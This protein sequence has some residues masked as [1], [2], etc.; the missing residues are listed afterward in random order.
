MNIAVMCYVFPPEV[1]PAGVM[2]R[3]LAEDLAADGHRVTLLVSW[4]NHPGGKLKEGWKARF[5]G[6]EHLSPR[7]R[8]VRCL[9]TIPNRKRMISRLMFYF[10]FGLTAMLNGLASGPFDVVLNH[11]TPIFGT[12]LGWLLARLKGA[13]LVYDIYD[14][15]PEAAAHAGLIEESALSYRVL[16][17]MDAELCRRADAI[18]TLSESLKRGIVERGV[19]GGKI[20]L[21]PLWLDPEKFPATRRDNPWRRAQG[22]PKDKFVALFAGTIGY[23]SGALVLADVAERLAGRQDILLL[24][25]GEGAVKD[26]LEAA[27]AERGLGN[28]M[29]LPYQPAEALANM[30]AAADVGLVTLLP[31]TGETSL[32]SKVLGYMAAGRAV[33]AGAPDDSDTAR[34]IRLGRCGTVSGCQDAEGMAE[35]IREAADHPRRTRDMGRRARKFLLAEYN[36]KRSTGVYKSVAVAVGRGEVPPRPAQDKKEK[37]T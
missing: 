25:V 3:E 30:Q 17:A 5:R 12:W 33:L 20:T 27:A 7:I 1:A 35:A 9:H 31:R 37:T 23:A 34:M 15:H 11:S 10:T 24:I 2:M 6:V 18:T 26:E 32:P 16:R 36:R 19:D 14:L 29:F 21:V 13:R 28:M 22:I 8:V 4:P